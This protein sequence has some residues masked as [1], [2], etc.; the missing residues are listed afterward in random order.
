MR[1]FIF[2]KTSVNAHRV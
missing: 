1:G 2:E